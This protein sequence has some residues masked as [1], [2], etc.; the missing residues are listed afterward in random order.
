M[1]KTDKQEGDVYVNEV[2][3]KEMKVTNVTEKEN[4]AI[5]N[6]EPTGN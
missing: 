4:Y 3:G 5:I 1:A 6:S 2:T